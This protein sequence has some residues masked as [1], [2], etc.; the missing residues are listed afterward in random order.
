[1]GVP[2]FFLWLWKRYKGN[3]FVF[4]KGSLNKENDSELIEKINTIDEF[5]LDLNCA[6]HPMCFK[7]L[8]ENQN[9]TNMERL[10][11]KMM[12]RVIEYIDELVEYVNPQQVVY[13]AIDGVAPIAK[14]KQQR[15]RRFKSI[16]DK[17]LFDNIKRKHNKEITTHWN[18]SAITPGTIFMEKLKLKIIDYCKKL[19][20]KR[21]IKVIFSTSNTPSEG[22]HKLLQYIRN[23][24][25][26]NIDN[27]NKYVIYGLDADLIFL[28]L[29][30]NKE[31]I[32]LLREAVHLNAGDS[33]SNNFDMLNYVSIDVM[34]SCIYQQIS[35]KILNY[36]NDM[37]EVDTNNINI[38]ETKRIIDDFIFICYLLGNDFL[39]HIPS[40]DI[41]KNGIDILI[42]IYTEYV[43]Y[44]I[45]VY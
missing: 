40:L 26:N 24:Q 18:N 4:S 36:I 42:K 5:L 12:N 38:I 30:T 21:K 41:T 15:S 11:N 3:N 22:E 6:I 32:F 20:E 34:R 33:N 31:N 43:I 17:V 37:D 28:A 10:E 39:P 13:L 8:A 25:K 29:S 23:K 44:M 45:I 2:G 1:M 16:N 7:V 27:S 9:I 14:I 19:Q 35:K